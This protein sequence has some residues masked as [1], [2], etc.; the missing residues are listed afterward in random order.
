MKERASGRRPVSLG[1]KT[2]V[3]TLSGA[4]AL[5]STVA[6]GVT[7]SVAGASMATDCNM[8][9]KTVNGDWTVCVNSIVDPSNSNFFIVEAGG[10]NSSDGWTGHIEIIGPNGYDVNT[11]DVAHEAGAWVENDPVIPINPDGCHQ[12]TVNV[13]KDNSGTYTLEATT[14]PQYLFC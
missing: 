5:L 10:D 9:V 2:G 13:W 6:L 7:P 1:K 12:W 3:V 11:Q 14:G 4:S 8:G